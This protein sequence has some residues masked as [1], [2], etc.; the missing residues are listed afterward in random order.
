MLSCGIIRTNDANTEEVLKKGMNRSPP[1][2]LVHNQASYAGTIEACRFKELLLWQ[3]M[4]SH[5]SR[6]KLF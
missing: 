6:R 4:I 5:R 1:Y 3:P 2:E